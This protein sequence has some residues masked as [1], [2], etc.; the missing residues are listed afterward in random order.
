MLSDE[1]KAMSSP[2]ARTIIDC[3]LNLFRDG[4]CSAASL[5]QI[6]MALESAYDCGRGDAFMAMRQPQREMFDA[7]N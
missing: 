2:T 6:G 3:W 7:A 4:G 1:F 5:A